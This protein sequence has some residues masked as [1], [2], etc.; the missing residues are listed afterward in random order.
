MFTG[1]AFA[2]RKFMGETF[3]T[4]P[5]EHGMMAFNR[6]AVSASAT[7]ASVLSPRRAGVWA[8]A[9]AAVAA[10]GAAAAADVAMLTLEG[11]LARQS[12][13][14]SL[15]GGAGEVT[16]SDVVAT[17]RDA[18]ADAELD[19][20]V[21]R[22]KDAALSRTQIEEL[23]TEF[24]A[25]R[26]AGK[27]VF[28]FAESFGPGELL[29]ASHADEVWLQ[30]GGVVTLP[31]MSIEEMYFADT[32]AWLGF[33][34]DFVQIG[35]YKGAS[36]SLVN[37][38]PSA[39]WEQ[40]INHLLDGL[41][42]QMHQQ[43][44]DGL[45]LTEAKLDAAMRRAWLS[46]GE[47]AIELGLVDREVDLDDMM[48]V[49]GEALGEEIAWRGDLLEEGGE[50]LEALASNPFLMMSKLFAAPDRSTSGPTIAV[51][52]L[53]GPIVDGD[54]A[55]GG[56]F[57]GG[58]VGSRTMRNAM[59]EIAEDDNIRGVVVF[60]DSPGGS[61]SASEVIWQGL[62]RLGEDKPVW[63]SVGDMAAS[64]GYYSAVGGQKIYVNPSSIVGSIGVVGGKLV[65]RDFLERGKI[66]VVEHARGPLAGMMSPYQTWT[67]EERALVRQEMTAVYEQFTGRVTAGRPGIDLSKTAEGRLFVGSEAVGLGMADK[68]GG[69]QSAIDDMAAELGLG[70]YDTLDFPA[71]QTLDEII[72]EAF[73]LAASPAAAAAP[74]AA[75][76]QAVLGR[77][78]FMM[79]RD[80]L[81]TAAMLR[82]TPVLLTLPA[83]IIVRD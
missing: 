1:E 56:L 80:T 54:S 67:D 58:S 72:E 24:A 28:V 81:E 70:E 34:A 17:V 21:V 35:D 11:E 76:L 74:Y 14:A 22:L 13:A 27:K 25:L 53:E 50:S 15:F 29:T 4:Q 68:V 57:G 8:A 82:E 42:D 61:A 38:K 43:L 39:A 23:G 65:M 52:H 12:K 51:L 64:G 83:A 69:L 20:V 49:L 5:L 78:R 3:T 71:P 59:N 6:S 40:N 9:L 66:N 44:G 63:V 47:T 31:G 30:A 26:R 16:F 10:C 18:A 7:R 77:E 79:V 48:T 41:Y 45:G 32:F 36:E 75:A 2:G 73:G 60:I 19:A 37:S 46:T 62:R 33:K 55:S